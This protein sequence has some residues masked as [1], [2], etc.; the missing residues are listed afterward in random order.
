MWR[1][2]RAFTWMR[3]RVL[4]NSLERSGA[5]DRLERLSL[6]LEQIGPL[7]AFGLIVPSMFALAALGAYAGYWMS[8]GRPSLMFEAIR[9]I[10]LVASGFCLIGPILM[11][12]M[13]RTSA[14][15]LLLLP[16]PRRTLYV[17]QA[18]GT[19]SDPWILLVV[20]LVLAVPV[21]LAIGGAFAAA[22]IALAAGLLLIACL[23]GHLRAVDHHPAPRRPR[24]PARR[25]G[26]RCSSSS[27]CR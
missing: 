5:R 21:G 4:L 11:P 8:T 13:E 25:A 1:T 3:W 12:S 20:P 22:A 26:R 10:V 14:I 23:I 27:S 2:L 9:F 24:S 6:A 16:I 18:A 7:I 17:A 19:V 15:R